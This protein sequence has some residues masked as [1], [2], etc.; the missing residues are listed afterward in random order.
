MVRI[1]RNRII[2]IPDCKGNKPIVK[3]Y[4]FFFPSS[5]TGCFLGIFSKII[6]T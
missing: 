4:L 6:F 2:D 3:Y 1:I 5:L